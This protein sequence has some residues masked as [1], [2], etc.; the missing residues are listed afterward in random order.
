MLGRFDGLTEAQFELIER[1]LPPAR[2][3]RGR[4]RASSLKVLNTLIWLLVNGAKWCSVPKGEQ[5]SPKSTAHDRIGEWEA[6]GTWAKVLAHLLGL[7]EIAGLIDWDRASVDGTFVP[8]KGGGEDV[9]YGYK[10]KGLTIHSLVDGNGMPLSAASTGASACESGQVEALLDTIDVQS[11]KVGRPKSRPKSLQADKSYDSRKLRNEIRRRG[12]APMIP[13]RMWPNRKPP[14]G[15]PPAKPTDRWKVERTFAWLQRKYRR[16][17]VRWERKNQYW[18]AFLG[19]GL[20]LL[21][22]ERILSA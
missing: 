15:R 10:G 11:G 17:A 5:W 14:V 3:G 16:L 4:P 2:T 8:G 22:M 21:W 12:I 7:A 20:C 9:D 13:R 1:L 19:L 18:R 6:D